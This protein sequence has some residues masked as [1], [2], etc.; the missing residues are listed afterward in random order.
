MLLRDLTALSGV[1]AL[2]A[3]ASLSLRPRGSAE[4][5]A[6]TPVNRLMLKLAPAGFFIYVVHPSP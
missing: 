3:I 1:F 5:H 6:S 2:F 4:D